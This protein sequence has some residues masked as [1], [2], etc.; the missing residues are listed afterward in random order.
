MPQLPSQDDPRN[1]GHWLVRRREVPLVVDTCA[2]A[3]PTA[4]HLS[5]SKASARA[6][7]GKARTRSSYFVGRAHPMPTPC[8]ELT[9]AERTVVLA[10]RAGLADRPLVRW[11]SRNDLWSALSRASALLWVLSE[12]EVTPLVRLALETFRVPSVIV[13]SPTE[14]PDIAALLAS[15]G[16]SEASVISGPLE[17]RSTCAALLAQLVEV[18]LRLEESDAPFEMIV[19]ES[20]PFG[21]T[22]GVVAAY[23]VVLRGRATPGLR[24]RIGHATGVAD[25]VVRQLTTFDT[26]GVVVEASVT[27]ADISWIRA[28]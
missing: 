28:R 17:D 6:T 16:R 12:S 27:V 20:Q 23:G 15:V 8:T 5:L 25:A 13:W 14:R 21:V 19:S 3:P 7:G 22:R 18:P 24:V 2:Q 1:V 10:A 9:V 26:A 11:N 4:L